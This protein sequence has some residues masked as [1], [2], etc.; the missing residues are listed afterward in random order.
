MFG[1]LEVKTKE[2][3]WTRYIDKKDKKGFYRCGYCGLPIRYFGSCDICG[4]KEDEGLGK[5]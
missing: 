1:C 4:Y 2:K 3:N 5:I